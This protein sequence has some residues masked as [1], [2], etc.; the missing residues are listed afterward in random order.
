MLNEIRVSLAR[1]Q[2]NAGILN[3][4]FNRR[5]VKPG[6]YSEPGVKSRTYGTRTT[7]KLKLRSP[8]S[9]GKRESEEHLYYLHDSLS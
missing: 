2:I 1:I 3:D 7:T 8:E 9:K 5:L 6:V 4:L